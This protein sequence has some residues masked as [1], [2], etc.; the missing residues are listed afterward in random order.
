MNQDNQTAG[1]LKRVTV[2]FKGPENADAAFS[3]IFGIGKNGLTPFERRLEGTLAGDAFE[4]M[5]DR[6][7]LAEWFA[8][9]T[10]ALPDLGVTATPAAY[11]VMVEA[12][13]PA[14]GQ[15]LIKAMAAMVDGCGCGC[16]C[17]GH[18]ATTP[19]CGAGN[20]DTGGCGG[21]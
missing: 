20:C 7:T 9:L 4:I 21:H 1:P 15:E 2:N 18:T 19:G 10:P 8:Y 6:S 13:A 17:G 11:S 3:F 16:G 5:L 12:V 14:D